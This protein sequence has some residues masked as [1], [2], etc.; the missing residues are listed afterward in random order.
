M[1]T[2]TS[3]LSAEVAALAGTRAVGLHAAHAAA[4]LFAWPRGGAAALAT[5]CFQ[6]A[7]GCRSIGDVD[8]PSVVVAANLQQQHSSHT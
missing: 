3:C 7:V 6:P 1:P 2:R 8:A 5:A 4:P